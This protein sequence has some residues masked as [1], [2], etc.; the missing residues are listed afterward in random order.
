MASK[1]WSFIEKLDDRQSPKKENYVSDTCTVLII[2]PARCTSFSNLYLEWKSTCFR[3]FLCP[4]SGVFHYTH[5]NDTRWFKYDW[6][7]NRLVYTQIVPVVFEPPCICHTGL[8]CV[9][10]KTPGD[11]QRN[12]PKHVDFHSKNKFE[13]LVHL[14]GFIIRI[15][16]DA[17]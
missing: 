3:Q 4:S 12:C 14:V 10:W 8:L 9:Q 7:C 5:S 1:T 16:L 15:Y 17:W 2:T 6:D 13:K 11:G